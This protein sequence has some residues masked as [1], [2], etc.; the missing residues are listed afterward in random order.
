[1]T[2][3]SDTPTLSGWYRF[4]GT[5]LGA[6]PQEAPLRVYVSISNQRVQILQGLIG[7]TV[8]SRSLGEFH[9]EWA[10]YFIPP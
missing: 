6:D 4:R 5:L 10:A 1:M 2:W 7:Q 3:T 8:Q 9:G